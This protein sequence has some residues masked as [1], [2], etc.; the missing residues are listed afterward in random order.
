MPELDRLKAQL[1]Y[2][3]YW[4]GILAVID[5]GLLGWL[6][7]TGSTPGALTLL[8]GAIGVV[9]LTCGIYV[10]HRQIAVGIEHVGKL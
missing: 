8:L 7:F 2:L 1:A 4:Q 9:A 6:I 10:L 5:I 3:R